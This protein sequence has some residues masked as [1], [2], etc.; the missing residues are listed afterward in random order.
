MIDDAIP[1]ADKDSLIV[2]LNVPD[3][4]ITPVYGS[5]ILLGNSETK[6]DLGISSPANTR[7]GNLHF[8]FSNVQQLIAT[9]QE[10]AS[11]P[12]VVVNGVAVNENLSNIT[13]SSRYMAVWWIG[14]GAGSIA[15]TA[16]IV[17]TRR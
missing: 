16:N 5:V 8:G 3:T 7:A 2:A 12:Y 1:T 13:A 9:Y 10:H 11:S 6:V 17:K 4:Q 15:V 14:A